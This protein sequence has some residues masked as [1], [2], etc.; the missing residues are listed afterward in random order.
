MCTP[1]IL[2][3]L[4]ELDNALEQTRDR[5]LL[6]FK[7]SLYCDRSVTVHGELMQLCRQPP[8]GVS[9]AVVTVQT[10]RRLCEEVARRLGVEHHTPQALVVV[11][12][13]V[14]WHARHWQVTAAAMRTA[15][16]VD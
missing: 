14:T 16:T 7:H 6:L 12:G 8:P 2:S 13:A 9:V 15:L 3:T 5:P 1:S 4:A 11:D 10:A